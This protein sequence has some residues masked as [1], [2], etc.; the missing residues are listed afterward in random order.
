[1]RAK[2]WTPVETEHDGEWHRRMFTDFVRCKVSVGEPSPHLACAVEM[3]KNANVSERL[4]R[5]G[6]YGAPYSILTSEAIWREWPWKRALEQPEALERWIYEN[7]AGFHIR[8]ERRMVRSPD[9]M[10]A[11]LLSWMTWCATEAPR[12][13]ASGNTRKA[14]YDEWWNSI[15][16]NVMYFGRY[17]TIRVMEFIRR[18]VG[19][20]IYLT[21]IRSMGAESPIRCLALLFPE[22]QDQLLHEEPGIA[23][24]LGERLLAQIRKDIPSVNHYVLAAMLCEYREAYEDRSQYAGWTIDQELEYQFSEKA[25]WWV[26]RGYATELFLVR[27]EIFPHEALG[28]LASPPWFGRRKELARMLRDEGRN[29]SDLTN[30]YQIYRRAEVPADVEQGVRSVAPA[31]S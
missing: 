29:W 22:W 31:R 25:R 14:L 8:K 12:R 24:T 18:S 30:D 17:I 19:V 7:W 26:Q 23:E 27:K 15:T 3:S 28:E 4:W 21:D 16:D 13:L 6:V 9:R 1:V 20:P 10:W 2:A 5:A 11:C